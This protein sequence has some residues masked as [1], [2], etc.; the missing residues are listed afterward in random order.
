M[1]KNPERIWTLYPEQRIRSK[2]AN[3]SD[4]SSST[5]GIPVVSSLGFGRFFAPM[6]CSIFAHL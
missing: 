3:Q 1:I 2:R 5:T 6:E 4:T